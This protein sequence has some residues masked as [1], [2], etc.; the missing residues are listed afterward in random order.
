MRKE[1]IDMTRQ[2]SLKSRIAGALLMMM[3]AAVAS[4]VSVV[5]PNDTGV[6]GDDDSASIQNAVD[7]AEKAGIGQVV[8]PAWN[9]RTGKSG[10]TLSRSILLPGNMTVVIDNARL[11][12]ADDVY[13]NFFRSANT[14]TEKGAT[15][16]GVLSNIRIIGRGFAVLHGAKANDLCEGTSR[17]DG[18]PHV[19]ANCPILFQNV[20]DFE[21][22]NLTI[23][24]HRYWGTCFCFCRRG[25]ISD[26]HFIARFDRNNQDGV[27][28]RDGCRDITI[29]NISG[30]TGDDMIALSAIDRRRT[31]GYNCWVDGLS[32]DICH[33]T[34][35][36]VSGA[37][38]GHPLIALRNHNG[39]RIY[40]ISINNV[41]DTPFEVPCKGMDMNRYAIIRIGN[42]IYWSSR[43]STLG[44]IS[45]IKIS[46]VRCSYSVE[47]I[48]VN[49]TLKDALFSDIHCTGPCASAVTTSGVVWG[50]IG[51]TI[52]NM[53]VEN[54]TV[55]SDVPDSAVFDYSFIN[56]DDFIRN[57]KLRNCTLVRDGL[58]IEYA[59]ERIERMFGEKAAELAVGQGLKIVEGLLV[60]DIPEDAKSNP[61]RRHSGWIESAPFRPGVNPVFTL[62]CHG[63]G[64]RITVEVS[65]AEDVDGKPGKW[66]DYAKI[67]DKAVVKL[68]SGEWMKYRVTMATSRTISPHLHMLRFGKTSH[69]KWILPQETA[70]GK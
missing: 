62:G 19:R 4:N 3:G 34:I 58:K 40:D 52:E 20:V 37:A 7:K 68:D 24:D 14:W 15:P 17:V 64:G 18:R 27:N 31:D 6:M 54:A 21:V 13:A 29:S 63:R 70:C 22:S 1:E 2:M 45:R 48:V 46:G 35:E 67:S 55:A 8:I 9:A 43:R 5:T 36:N 60:L 26:L 38:V 51:A 42:R 56:S 23:E 65:K 50:G 11:S 69:S 25:K 59:D 10:W 66:S 53:T 47:G 30:Q 41:V 16:E 39:S 44:E 49:N 33:V 57:V 12:L 61:G 28:L 32:P